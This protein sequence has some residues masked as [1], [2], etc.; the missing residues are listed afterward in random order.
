MT[1][2]SMRSGLEVLVTPQYLLN[3]EQ[4]RF[5]CDWLSIKQ[6]HPANT[7]PVI[8]DG[9]VWATDE[10]GEVKWRTIKGKQVEGSHETSV[11]VRC[12][13]TTVTFSGNVSR[14]GRS[15]NLWGYSLDQCLERINTVIAELGLPPFTPGEPY[16]RTV[17]TEHGAVLKR[18]WTGAVITRM[19]LTA[20]YETGSLSNARAYMAWLGTQQ[21][22]AR[23]KVGT[24]SD[25]E[26]IDWGRGSRAVYAK[27]YLK[28][29]ELKKH[30]GPDRLIDHCESVGLVRFEVTLKSTWLHNHDCNYLG[31]LD[32]AEIVK[33]FEERAKVL[34][35]AEHEHDDLEHLK[36]R[37]LRCTARDWL[38]GDDVAA[39]MAPSTF[40]RHRA[41][42]LKYGI[43]ISVKRNVV[44]FKPQVRVIEVKPA[45]IPS[46]YDLDIPERKAA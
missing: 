21:T 29:A 31:G 11:Q 22:T 20:N 6:V 7:L 2:V 14:F 32:M 46:W 17:K 19:D 41:Q 34:T 35:R 38:A 16:W 40:R 45:Q 24:L 28:S 8:T 39:R 10:D 27:S 15:N 33:I 5:F 30:G 42:L 1:V 44:N 43:D 26:T 23:I 4:E 12:D 25:G 36:S 9:A 3:S 13:G 37:A 18:A